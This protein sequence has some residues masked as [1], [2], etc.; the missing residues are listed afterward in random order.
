MAK[1]RPERLT[2]E[3]GTDE[4][5]DRVKLTLERAHTAAIKAAKDFTEAAQI[6]ARGHVVD[7]CGGASVAISKPSY[8]LRVA[9]ES[10]GELKRGPS[11]IWHISNFA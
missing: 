4:F 1:R 2:K 5:I 3:D 10:L 8:R 9:L 7:A 6:N 11:G